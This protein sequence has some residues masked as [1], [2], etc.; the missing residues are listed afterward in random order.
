MLRKVYF[1]ISFICMA[2]FLSAYDNV[3]ANPQETPPS[4]EEKFTEVGYKTVNEAVKEFE[5]HFKQDVKLP[6]I[7][8]SIAFSH[9]FGRF[10]EDKYDINDFLSIHFVNEKLPENNYKIDIRPLKN[11]L[12]FK[13]KGNQKMYALQNG[14]KAIYM[15]APIMNVLV[16][17][18]DNWQYMLGIDKKISNKVTPEILVKIADSIE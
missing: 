3:D 2:V 7:M 10:F 18:K 8:P 9:Q 4:I 5:N 17:E 11:K 16:F 13:D 14:E 15:N 6:K 12:I 1:M